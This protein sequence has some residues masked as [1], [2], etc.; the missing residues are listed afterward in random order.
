MSLPSSMADFVPCD[1]LLQKTYSFSLSGHVKIVQPRNRIQVS[2][3]FKGRI[4]LSGG[5][6]LVSISAKI[7]AFALVTVPWSQTFFLSRERAASSEAAGKR[8]TSGYLGLES[9]F[10]ADA[11]LRI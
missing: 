11:R 10:H 9:H 5:Y 8:K 2:Q 6:S 3:F 1:R 4:T 7:S